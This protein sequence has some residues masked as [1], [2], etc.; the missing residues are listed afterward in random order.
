MFDT[1]NKLQVTKPASQC[2]EVYA[3][4]RFYA[5]HAVD[6]MDCAKFGKN[7]ALLLLPTRVLIFITNARVPRHSPLVLL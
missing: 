4:L 3:L 7:T 2:A 1:S 6:M 5:R